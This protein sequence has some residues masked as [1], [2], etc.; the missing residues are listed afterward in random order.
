[1]RSLVEKFDLYAFG[2]PPLPPYILKT[3][4][5]QGRP[6]FDSCSSIDTPNPFRTTML[7]TSPTYSKKTTS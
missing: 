7:E 4:R 5:T 3:R 1:M 2:R 6:D